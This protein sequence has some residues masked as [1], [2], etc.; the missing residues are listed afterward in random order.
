MS[1]VVSLITLPLLAFSL[2]VFV[3][4]GCRLD[5]SS[6]GG[7]VLACKNSAGGEQIEQLTAQV[8]DLEKAVSQVQSLSRSE[9]ADIRMEARVK[10]KRFDSSL[11]ELG[12]NMRT[13]IIDVVGSRDKELNDIKAKLVSAEA[14][15]QPLEFDLPFEE[16]FGGG[17]LWWI[18]SQGG[19]TEFQNPH[20]AGYV[21]ASRSAE[22][23]SFGPV[24]AFTGR[25]VTNMHTDNI[26]NAW[27]SVDL[28]EHRSIR[29]SHYCLRTRQAYA[30]SHSLRNWVLESSVNTVDWITISTHIND[31][32][33]SEA[34]ITGCWHIDTAVSARAFRVRQTG[35]NSNNQNFLVSSGIEFYGHA[36]VRKIHNF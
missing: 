3:Q 34:A 25:E 35:P 24:S 20:I 4:S 15:L 14:R 6:S 16:P 11:S 32:S 29:A 36:T 22:A 19:T 31:T 8:G 21:V 30:A 28:G 2:V 17:F 1:V 5:L 9:I 27:L 12:S 13:H 26:A 23:G 18:G 10:D 33:L 7:G